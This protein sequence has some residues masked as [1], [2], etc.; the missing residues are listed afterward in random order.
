MFDQKLIRL[1][2]RIE[3]NYQG[4]SIKIINKII[5]YQ[6][7]EQKFETFFKFKFFKKKN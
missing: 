6:R 1:N 5:N 3:L 4:I 2:L 7:K